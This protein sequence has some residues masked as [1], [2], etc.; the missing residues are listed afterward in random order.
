MLSYHWLRCQALAQ[1][2]LYSDVIPCPR[3]YQQQSAASEMQSQIPRISN[4]AETGSYGGAFAQALD[5][6]FNVKGFFT[7]I[8]LQK[9]A[10]DLLIGVC[11]DFV[12]AF[13][14]RG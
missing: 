5:D 13:R 12:D 11:V 2:Y 10:F 9:P 6:F 8:N 1:L 14:N 3:K 7:E 4:L